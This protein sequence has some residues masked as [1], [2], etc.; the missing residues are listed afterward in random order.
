M[1]VL[2]QALLLLPVLTQPLHLLLLLL[3]LLV[4][5]LHCQLPLLLLSLLLLRCLTAL[6]TVPAV[7][8]AIAGVQGQVLENNWDGAGDRL[9]TRQPPNLLG[10]SLLLACKTSTTAF[11]CCG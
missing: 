8:H 2:L 4:Q 9:L 11:H 1:L 3:L 10:W 5:L 7:R 6:D